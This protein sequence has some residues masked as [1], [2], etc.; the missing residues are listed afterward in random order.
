MPFDKDVL[1]GL[2]FAVPPV[3]LLETVRVLIGEMNY[4]G[5]TT[6]LKEK[7]DYQMQEFAMVN[8]CTSNV[9]GVMGW[10]VTV[11]I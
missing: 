7:W 9:L 6:V 3:V 5:T 8:L 10:S 2:T 11:M 1:M 4:T